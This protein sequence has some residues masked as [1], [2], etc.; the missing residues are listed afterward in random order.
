MSCTLLNM[1]YILLSHLITTATLR[2]LPFSPCYT[3]ATLSS[4]VKNVDSHSA[5]ETQLG[6]ESSSL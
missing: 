3:C 5:R 1:L 4:E 2:V 6:N